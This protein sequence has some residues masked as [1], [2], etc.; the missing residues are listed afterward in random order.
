M[1][2]SKELSG[3]TAVVT[4]ASSGIGR[5]IAET[6][7]GAGAHVVLGGRTDKAMEESV[8]R[9]TEGGGSAQFSVG[10]IRDVSVPAA[11]VDLAVGTTG[12]LDIMVN[13]A[14]VSFPEPI[15]EADPE[16]WRTML[17]TNVLALLVGSQAAVKAMRA[18]GHP[19]HIVNISSVAALRR[20]SGVYGATKH[21]VN[22]IDE[23]LRRELQDDP[24]KIITIMPGAIA[25]S[26]ARNFDTAV[27]Q[28]MV[29]LA[30]ADSGAPGAG[31]ADVTLVK[32]E[33]I[34]DE[35]LAGARAGLPEHLCAP[36]DVAHAVLWAVTQPTEV[37]IAE[38]VVRPNR[39]LAL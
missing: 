36:Q 14:G 39:D 35:V 7:G 27:L 31:V 4:G 34:P 17:E 29:S 20:D 22:A 5:A 2:S 24:I 1:S 8:A 23:T 10:D 26:F 18:G 38:L 25:T 9:I 19:G 21:A 11:L 37:H 30:A 16:H 33:R 3:R 15:L 28:T 32:G 13:N 6:L 12:R